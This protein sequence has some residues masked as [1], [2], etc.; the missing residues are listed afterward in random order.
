M[1]NEEKIEAKKNKIRNIIKARTSKIDAAVLRFHKKLEANTIGKFNSFLEKKKLK[2]QAKLEKLNKKFE[3]QFKKLT[4]LLEVKLNIDN[5]IKDI[6]ASVDKFISRA[7]SKFTGFVRNV[8]EKI[9]AFINANFTSHLNKLIS[10]ISGGI[11]A[12]NAAL[13]TMNSFLSELNGYK[14]IILNQ[15][16]ALVTADWGAIL[17]ASLD[18]AKNEALS[19]VNSLLGFDIKNLNLG[20]IG[21]DLTKLKDNFFERLKGE[22]STSKYIQAMVPSLTGAIKANATILKS[23]PDFK[24]ILPKLKSDINVVKQIKSLLS[25]LG[26]TGSLLEKLGGVSLTSLTSGIT[27]PSISVDKVMENINGVSKSISSK[28]SEGL[29]KAISNKKITPPTIPSSQSAEIKEEKPTGEKS[30]YG[31]I[32]VRE[33]KGGFVQIMDETPGNVRQVD[34]HPSGSYTS[35]LDNGDT[36]GK[37]TGKRVDIIDKNWEIT[38]FENQILIVNKDTKIEIR[39]DKFENIHGNENHNIEKEKKTKVKGN[40]SDDFGSDYNC[41]ISGNSNKTI[42]GNSSETISGNKTNSISGSKQEKVSGNLTI[43]VSGNVN[44]TGA[45]VNVMASSQISLSAPK[46]KIN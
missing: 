33:N 9:T 43:N 42:S 20:D 38:V 28:L 37:T 3:K 14:D 8:G 45:K 18:F 44:I 5:Y 46:V 7:V 40:V 31:K 13:A 22:S 34:L 27:I 30:E 23:T 17:S 6:T 1:T 29:S 21:K 4:H 15:W 16:N 35:K 11:D 12:V 24:I 26:Q 41:K 2:L 10:T 39:N 25:S 32:Q 19:F 36:H